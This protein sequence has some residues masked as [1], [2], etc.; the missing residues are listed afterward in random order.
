MQEGVAVLLLLDVVNGRPLAGRPAGEG[1]WGGGVLT[2]LFP[3]SGGE[4][5][6]CADLRRPEAPHLA[7]RAHLIQLH[8]GFLVPGQPVIIFTSEIQYTVIKA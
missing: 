7:P 2:Q 4:T 5:Q 1:G 3:S 6:M 8:R